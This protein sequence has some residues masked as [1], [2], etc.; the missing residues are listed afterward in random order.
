[1]GARDAV[2]LRSERTKVFRSQDNLRND[3]E[4][5]KIVPGESH[6]FP[7]ESHSGQQSRPVGGSIPFLTVALCLDKNDFAAFNLCKTLGQRS[8]IEDGNV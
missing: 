8:A 6:S 5:K 7:R 4:A 2:L 3:Q 1:M